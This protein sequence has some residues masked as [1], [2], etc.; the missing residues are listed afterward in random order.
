MPLAAV[1]SGPG[2]SHKSTASSSGRGAEGGVDL[3]TEKY[4]YEEQVEDR[5]TSRNRLREFRESVKAGFRDFRDRLRD[6]FREVRDRFRGHRDKSREDWTPW[7]GNPFSM[8][9]TDVNPNS[10]PVKGDKWDDGK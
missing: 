1:K 5:D 3:T 2:K 4:R 10:R 8:W 6:T 7:D 9:V